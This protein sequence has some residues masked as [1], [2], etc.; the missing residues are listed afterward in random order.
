MAEVQ[1]PSNP[2]C[3]VTA[4]DFRM[5]VIIYLRKLFSKCRRKSNGKLHR[6]YP[7]DR[8]LGGLQNQSWRRVEG[9][10]LYSAET[11]TPTPRSSSPQ[12]VAIPT[13]L[14]Q[15]RQAESCITAVFSCLS[16]RRVVPTEL[17]GMNT[18]QQT[19]IYNKQMTSTVWT[20]HSIVSADR[21][22][23]ERAQHA[24]GWD[25]LTDSHLY[26]MLHIT[27]TIIRDFILNDRHG[28]TSYTREEALRSR[29]R[30]L[31]QSTQT[32]HDF[33]LFSTR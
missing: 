29:L 28:S 14:S 20:Q 23:N 19:R 24:I 30:M 15:F 12:L 1:K 16:K 13:A 11:W 8:K 25:P 10:I 17:T 3:I 33:L 21:L 7:F 4:Y 27:S 22:W 6:I 26:Y 18:I 2:E 5:T 9:K 32:L 31:Q